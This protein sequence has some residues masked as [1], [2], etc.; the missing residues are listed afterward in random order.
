MVFFPP[1]PLDEL[2]VAHS[3][4]DTALATAKSTT[5]VA[6]EH[7]RAADLVWEQECAAAMVIKASLKHR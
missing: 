7:E 5:A 6:R 3:A 2:I 4:L 1:V